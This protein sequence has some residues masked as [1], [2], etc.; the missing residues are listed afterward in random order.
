MVAIPLFC[1]QGNAP[2]SRHEEKIYLC[3]LYNKRYSKRTQFAFKYE[4]NLHKRLHNGRVKLLFQ[5]RG[6]PSNN[7][8]VQ[9][10]VAVLKIYVFHH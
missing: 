6:V 2:L 4:F 8:T 9:S 10:Q 5:P 1:S 7:N 3:F